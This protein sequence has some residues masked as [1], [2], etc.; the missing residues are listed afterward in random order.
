LPSIGAKV[1]N[2]ISAAIRAA[3]LGNRFLA[4]ACDL[5]QRMS[6]PLGLLKNTSGDYKNEEGDLLEHLDEIV[7]VIRD[8]LKN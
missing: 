8:I 5:R 6:P 4:Q 2:K 3:G 1:K 7:D